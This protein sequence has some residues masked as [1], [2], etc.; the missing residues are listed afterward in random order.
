[1]RLQDVEKLDLPD[2]PGV[3][4][5]KDGTGKT[6]Y[7]G[8]AT[9]L[10]S[11]VRSYFSGVLHESRGE[12]IVGMVA[13]A[14]TVSYEVCLNALEA[15][16]LEANAIRK[17]KPKYN[18]RE[19]DDKSYNWV[20]ITKEKFPCV[21]LAREK[22]IDLTAKKLKK[23]GQ[24]LQ[25]VF[26]PY[27]QGISIR[28]GLRILRRIF[29][30]RDTIILQK[31]REVFY[32]QIGL[33]PDLRDSE[34]EKRYGETISRI[35]L[36]LA[37]KFK[38]LRKTLLAQMNEAA[39][40]EKFERAQSIKEKLFALDHIQDVALLRR[41]S[42]LVT[43]PKDVGKRNIRV[44]AYDIA[45]TSGKSMVGVMVVIQNGEVSKDEYRKFNI[46]SVEKSNDPAALREVLLRRL[47]H[48]YPNASGGRATWD[49]PQIIVVDGNKVQ[50]EAAEAVLMER[51]FNI[52]VIAVVKDKQ[53]KPKALL[54]KKNLI[55]AHKHSILLSN[56]EAHRFALHFHKKKR[57]AQFLDKK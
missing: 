47:D 48:V 30:F 53:H 23:D 44:E 2:V 1:M 26:G 24:K 19:K 28:E 41:E 46:R 40:E 14:D 8:K 9:S 13:L 6:L 45:H 43:T 37:G 11:R 17:E 31:D 16:I 3:Y 57:G 56:H 51:G 54:G 7:I 18:T 21:F 33:A 42:G 34:A 49:L 29:P 55:L 36:F 27:P 22:D 39:E 4:F 50:K 15:L 32:R 10:R 5:F 25:A 38:E 20:V 52:D 35:K 12:H